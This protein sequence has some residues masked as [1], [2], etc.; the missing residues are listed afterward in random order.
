[1]I[2]EIKYEQVNDNVN[3]VTYVYYMR[4]IMINGVLPFMGRK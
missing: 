2:I 4:V 1:M 3:I